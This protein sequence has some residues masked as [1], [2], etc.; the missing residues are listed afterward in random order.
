VTRTATIAS[1]LD[2]LCEGPT[3]RWLDNAQP[4][5]PTGSLMVMSGGTQQCAAGMG[6]GAWAVARVRLVFPNYHSHVR[7]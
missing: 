3:A 2:G 5:L 7:L 1:S 6:P 4:A